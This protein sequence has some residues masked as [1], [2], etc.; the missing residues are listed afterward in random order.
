ML[1]QGS[2]STRIAA[3]PERVWELVADV[4]RMGEWSPE[5]YRCEWLSVPPGPRLGAHFRG[6]N[7]QGPFRWSLECVVTAC[8]PGQELAFS[9]LVGASEATR[10]RYAL[11]PADGGTDVV[12]S[13]EWLKEFWLLQ[14]FAVVFKARRQAALITGMQTT[15][16][17]LKRVAESPG[18]GAAP[19]VAE[20]P[21]Q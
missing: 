18:I 2:A 5:C 6:H 20:S 9:T 3:L 15:L 1:A 10:W 11:R 21:G 13:F 16:S 17:R 7:R 19:G 8:R 14:P 12:Q 4:T